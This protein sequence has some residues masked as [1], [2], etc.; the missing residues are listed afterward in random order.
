MKIVF[1][2]RNTTSPKYKGILFYFGTFDLHRENF[3]KGEYVL[4]TS[5][6]DKHLLIPTVLKFYR[7]FNMFN[8]SQISFP[9]SPEFE[10]L[11]LTRCE[12][13]MNAGRIS[14]EQYR[15]KCYYKYPYIYRGQLRDV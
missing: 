6:N 5:S 12:K 9:V 7:R 4:S 2:L 3:R 8:I 13:L 1:S 10:S 11:R 14:F 15:N